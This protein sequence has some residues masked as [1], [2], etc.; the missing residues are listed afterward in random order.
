MLLFNQF[1]NVKG[2]K[3][4]YLDSEKS[5]DEFANWLYE[6]KKQTNE[7]LDFSL[8]LGID[9]TG[10]DFVE[11][12]KGKYDT[13]SCEIV[14]PFAETLN[15]KNSELIVYQGEPLIRSGSIIKKGQVVDTYCT[16]NPYNMFYF[17]ALDELHNNGYNVSFCVFGKLNDKNKNK[18]IEFIKNITKK[19]YDDYIIDYE[20]LGENYYCI[21]YT[22]RLVKMKVLTR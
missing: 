21:V 19:M 20:T 11:I 1:K 15:Q 22:K 4:S 13:A 17:G 7:Y 6:L 8:S 16:H 18:K 2:Y 10:C 9:L 14:S 12:N 5:L 3:A